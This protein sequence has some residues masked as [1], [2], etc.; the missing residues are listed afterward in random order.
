MTNRSIQ[1]TPVILS[2]GQ[3]TRLWPLSRSNQ[4]K[5][6][7]PL[8]SDKSLFE[9]TVE[10]CRGD[11]FKNPTVLCAQ[12][13]RFLVKKLLPKDLLETTKVIMEPCGRNTAAAICAA[14]LAAENPDD[15][16]LVLPSDHYIP[17]ANAFQDTIARAIP[18]AKNG[19]IVTF[20]I[21]PTSPH[22]GF[23]YIEQGEEQVPGYKIKKFHEKPDLEKA[24][25]YLEQ[26]GFFWNAGIFMFRADT[27][28]S[29][30]EIHAHQWQAPA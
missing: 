24:M 16:L 23:G 26:G 30:M 21:T 8:A 17:D 27:L 3:G 25:S 22:T 5:Q 28:L 29:E 20:G 19:N 10:R 18:L 7:I 2:G 14:A 13:H 15:I 9:D 4:P 1:I 11:I 6:F 12:Q